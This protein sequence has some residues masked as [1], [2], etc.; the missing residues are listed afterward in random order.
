MVIVVTVVVVPAV[1]VVVEVVVVVVV[2]G[3]ATEDHMEHLLEITLD[4]KKI[5]KLCRKNICIIKKPLK[6]LDIWMFLKS[7]LAKGSLRWLGDAVNDL[8]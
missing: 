6:Y 2:V 8:C 3:D 5:Q 4:H 1:V 7:K